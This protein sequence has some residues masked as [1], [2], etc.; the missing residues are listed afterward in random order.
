MHVETASF[1]LEEVPG[2]T[3]IQVSGPVGDP[4]PEHHLRRI[5]W[6]CIARATAGTLLVAD[7]REAYD[8]TS[9]TCHLLYGAFL[10]AQRS[11]VRFCLAA[12]PPEAQR[13]LDR[14]AYS[15]IVPIHESVAAAQE[16]GCVR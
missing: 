8:F 15:R 5:L 3:V 16:A 12:V 2:V 14:L 10:A 9:D 7:L 11:D 13:R 6:D 4:A 1:Q